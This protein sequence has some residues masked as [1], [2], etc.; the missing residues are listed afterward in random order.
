MLKFQGVG[1]NGKRYLFQIRGVS[2]GIQLSVSDD[3]ESQ[4]FVTYYIY[5]TKLLS[6][7]LARLVERSYSEEAQ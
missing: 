7:Q 5:L 6:I 2:T 4:P 3:T 1:G